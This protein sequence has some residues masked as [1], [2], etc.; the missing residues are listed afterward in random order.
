MCSLVL[1]GSTG[2]VKVALDVGTGF[3]RQEVNTDI[4]D[5]D[6]T[7]NQQHVV[8]VNR[9]DKGRGVTIAVDDYPP[10]IKH[11]Q[12]LPDSSDTRLDNPKFIYFGRNGQSPL[13]YY[14]P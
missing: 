4:Q 9:F 3:E 8:K 11:W 14:P 1:C 2:G 7:N 10:A 6:L 5:V 12:D 13:V